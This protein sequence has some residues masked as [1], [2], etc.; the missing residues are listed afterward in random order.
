MVSNQTA[1]KVA[2]KNPTQPERQPDKFDVDKV[3]D[4]WNVTNSMRRAMIKLQLRPNSKKQQPYSMEERL[5]A[6]LWHY[7]SASA[8]ERM[9]KAGVMLPHPRSVEVWIA[10]NEV[11]PGFLT[12]SLTT[13]KTILKDLPKS[14]RS[15][16]GKMDEMDIMER[17]EYDSKMDNIEGFEDLGHLGRTDRRANKVFAMTLNG[18]DPFYRWRI[19]AEKKQ[20]RNYDTKNPSSGIP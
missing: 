3:L 8:Y 13:L 11:Y 7:H 10:K 5:L 6:I 12:V 17:L 1:H 4:E 18:L 15:C 20:T 14:A 9:R 19:V 2:I 16:V